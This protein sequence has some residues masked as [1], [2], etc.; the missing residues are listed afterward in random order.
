MSHFMATS[1]LLVGVYETKIERQNLRTL[2]EKLNE[3]YELLRPSICQFF[4][5]D[6]VISALYVTAAVTA[7]IIAWESKMNIAKR[8]EVEFLVRLSAQDQISRAIEL[9]GISYET[10]RIGVCIVSKSVES[11]EMAK[12]RLEALLGCKLIP[13][14]DNRSTYILNELSK[15]Y[16]VPEQALKLIQAD[17]EFKALEL[18]LIEK[19]AISLI[20]R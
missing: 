18:F 13:F 9:V 8:L 5:A 11:L 3:V 19:I 17:S 4:N 6:R 10:E 15:I 2:L 16:D 1:D 20:S 12:S 14:V 7:A